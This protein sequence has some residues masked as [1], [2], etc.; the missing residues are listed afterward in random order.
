MTIGSY[1]TTDGKRFFL[2]L[3]PFLLVPRLIFCEFCLEDDDQKVEE[4]EGATD[5]E[6][7]VEVEEGMEGGEDES[8]M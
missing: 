3:L 2:F 7:A 6:V 4:T 8:V 5:N 1:F